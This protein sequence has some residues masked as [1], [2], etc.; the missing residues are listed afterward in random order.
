MNMRILSSKEGDRIMNM[1][2]L[3]SKEGDRIMNMRVLSRIIME[4]EKARIG[5]RKGLLRIQEQIIR[6]KVMICILLSSS[7]LVI[8]REEMINQVWFYFILFL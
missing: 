3:S 8:I 2:V 4:K 1:R 5:C 7:I 6:R